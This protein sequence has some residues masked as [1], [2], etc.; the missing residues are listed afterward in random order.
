LACLYEPRP[1][2]PL[3]PGITAPTWPK[4]LVP[5]TTTLSFA[6]GLYIASCPANTTFT[7]TA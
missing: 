4:T 6:K 2:V 3:T 5:A 7:A 1:A